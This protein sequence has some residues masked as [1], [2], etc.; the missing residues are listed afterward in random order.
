[1]MTNRMK[2]NI[3][4]LAST[5]VSTSIEKEHIVIFDKLI[6]SAM[7]DGNDVL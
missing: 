3:G 4:L 1:M 5:P 2:L 6:R 7:N